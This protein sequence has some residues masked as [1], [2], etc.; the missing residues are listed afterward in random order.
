MPSRVLSC[1][2]SSVHLHLM[3]NITTIILLLLLSGCSPYKAVLEPLQY[4]SPDCYCR[5]A[6]MA[7]HYYK[8]KLSDLSDAG[9]IGQA[10]K[11]SAVIL[12]HRKVA[13]TMMNITPRN[14]DRMCNCLALRQKSLYAYPKD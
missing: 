8:C 4:I 13:E 11:D 12:T 10:A 5:Y 14:R 6:D 7:I 9:I 1:G 3:K 2:S